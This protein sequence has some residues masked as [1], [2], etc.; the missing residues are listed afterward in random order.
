M[1]IL[2]INSEGSLYYKIKGY[3]FYYHVSINSYNDGENGKYWYDENC[4]IL[5]CNSKKDY[6][7]FKKLKV[8]W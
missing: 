8:L 5:N 1:V 2:Y 6:D 4:K 3:I 7:R